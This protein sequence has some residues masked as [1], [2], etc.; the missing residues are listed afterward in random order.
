MDLISAEEGLSS[1]NVG[2]DEFQDVANF[3]GWEDGGQIL[4]FEN[5][6]K[7]SKPPPHCFASFLF[8]STVKLNGQSCNK[9]LKT[10][11]HKI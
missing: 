7:R 4:V 1:L 8:L 6:K 2:E 11:N 10:R 3:V 9:T 5:I